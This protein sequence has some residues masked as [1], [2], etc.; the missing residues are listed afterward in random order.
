MCIQILITK[1]S[2]I[3]ERFRRSW[4]HNQDWQSRRSEGWCGKQQTLHQIVGIIK[5]HTT[6]NS[7]SDLNNSP[8]YENCYHIHIG[9]LKIEFI[10]CINIC[11]VFYVLSFNVLYI[12]L[13]YIAS[14]RHTKYSFLSWS[15]KYFQHYGPGL[16]LGSYSYF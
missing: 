13:K 3:G 1:Y 5:D 4:F 2:V 9:I 7:R 12:I 8:W 6:V 15:I 11:D 16:T 14:A 10:V